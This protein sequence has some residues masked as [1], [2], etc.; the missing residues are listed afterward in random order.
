MTD[1]AVLGAGS[2]GTALADLL[3]RKGLDVCL[4]A[5][6]PEVAES[7]NQRHENSLYF[8]G[9]PLA[10]T[11]RATPDLALAVQGAPHV[12]A[13]APSHVTRQVLTRAAPSV[14]PGATLI[15]ASKGIETDTLQ[16]MCGVAEEVMPDH[17]FVALSGPSFADEVHDAQPTAV[18][19]ASR[20][21]DRTSQVQQLFATGY[22][23]V[24]SS[25]DVIGVE[26][27][28][29]L[30]NTI[31]IAAG[32]LDGMG[33]GHNPRAALLTRGLA[34]IARL[35]QLL[36]AEA[37]TFAGLAGM[38]D[39]ILTCTGGLSRNRQL[40]IALAQGS[41]LEEFRRTHRVVAE[42]AN[43]A[44]AASRL[45]ERH[46][47]EMPITRSVAAILFEG[48]EPRQCLHSLMERSLKAEQWG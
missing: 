37:S 26:L 35:G 6:E 43:T 30:K 12:C 4:W 18:V 19:A 36:G 42:G 46:G 9:R 1:I 8:A 44:L 20:H 47:V 40:G 14:R 22:F 10:P 15:C 11:L 27:G 21:E 33:L 31:A 29:S 7:I 34:E 28:G 2:W 39:L 41:S 25:S 48:A 13:V 32:I 3:S 17:P 24:Y 23:R 16:L 45:A 38:G 5:H